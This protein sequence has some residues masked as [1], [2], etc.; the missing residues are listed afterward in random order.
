MKFLRILLKIFAGL[1]AVIGLLLA[2]SLSPNDH[3]PY[4]Q[5]DFYR[6]TKQ[7][8]DSLS[9]LP[10]PKMGIRTGIRAGWAKARNSAMPSTLP[11]VAMS[12]WRRIIR[13]SGSIKSMSTPRVTKARP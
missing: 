6:Q 7:R 11:S 10:K 12:R 8:L 2:I 3:T 5:T 9:A 13:I 1:L 4:G